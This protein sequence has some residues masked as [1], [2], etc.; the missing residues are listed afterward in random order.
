MRICS[1]DGKSFIEIEVIEVELAML[2]STSVSAFIE[3]EGFKGFKNNCWFEHK[4]IQDF[5]NE[6]K[7]LDQK[8]QGKAIL[9]SMSPSDLIL[10]IE[11]YD[12]T[13]HIALK[14]SMAQTIGCC[15]GQ[16]TLSGGFILDRSES[17]NIVKF[18]EELLM[19]KN[20]S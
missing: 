4:E 8:Q 12:K 16:I 10:D 13:G 18:F 14:Y 2:P 7:E 19:Q 9:S 20:Q 15:A 6:L 5:I 17:F 3:N 1:Q 11:V